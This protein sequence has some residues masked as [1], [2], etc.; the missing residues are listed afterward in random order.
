[1][2]SWSLVIKGMQIKATRT[3]HHTHT[4]TGESTGQLDIMGHKVRWPLW[5][6]LAT[7]V[8]THFLIQ[9]FHS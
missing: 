8:N 3:H 7:P 6:S 1:M 5:K 4:S 9:E 2:K